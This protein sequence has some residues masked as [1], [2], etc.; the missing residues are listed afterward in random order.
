[1]KFSELPPKSSFITTYQSI[2]GWKAVHMW[3]NPDMGG[4]YE[5][6][7]TGMGGYADEKQAIAEAKFWAEAD[8][9]PYVERGA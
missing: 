1:M 2:G 7:N 4:F 8:E 3:W 6:Y 9:L 5:P